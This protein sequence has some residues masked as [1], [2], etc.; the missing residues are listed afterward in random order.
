MEKRNSQEIRTS[1]MDVKKTTTSI[2]LLLALTVPT[3]QA[4]AF[5]L[6]KALSDWARNLWNAVSHVW[7]EIENWAKAIE[8]WVE[9]LWNEVSKELPRVA[10]WLVAW[11]WCATAVV[12]TPTSVMSPDNWA[13]AGTVAFAW[14]AAAWYEKVKEEQE[15]SN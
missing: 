11:A 2:A 10:G 1:K 9:H 15:R 6:W 13:I 4:S 12:S 3:S 5:N 14:C 8:E 7:R